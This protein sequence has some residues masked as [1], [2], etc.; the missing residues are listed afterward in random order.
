M[1][2]T[3]GRGQVDTT[4]RIGGFRGTVSYIVVVD[5]LVVSVS[6]LASSIIR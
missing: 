1:S 4:H 2:G 3:K 5:I 6:H